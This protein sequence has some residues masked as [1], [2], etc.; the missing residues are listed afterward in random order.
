MLKNGNKLINIKINNIITNIDISPDNN[1]LAISGKNG[2]LCL[3]NIIKNS[4][5]DIEIFHFKNQNFNSIMFS[6]TGETLLTSSDK[7]SFQIWQIPDF[8]LINDM[9]VS[10]NYLNFALFDK[11]DKNIVC[12]DGDQRIKIITDLKNK[13]HFSLYSHKNEVL[14]AKFIIDDQVVSVGNDRYLK[15][16]DIPSKRE[17]LSIKLPNIINDYPVNDLDIKCFEDECLVSVALSNYKIV[18]YKIRINN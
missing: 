7:G 10:K 9:T 17:L 14:K 2:Y 12:G 11:N 5:N 18:V 8:K 1:F 3:Y 6:H 13:K 15:I 4:L 16:F